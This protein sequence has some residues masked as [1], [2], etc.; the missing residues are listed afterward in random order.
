MK[1]TRVP[2][3]T[4]KFVLSNLGKGERF[5][6][7]MRKI[8]TIFY[9]L[10]QEDV[11]E[12][13]FEEFVFDTSK[14]YPYSEEVY[15]AFDRLQKSNLL[16]IINNEEYEITES[17]SKTDPSKLFT[18]KEMELLKEIAKKFLHGLN[19]PSLSKF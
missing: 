5:L 8:N 7:N 18:E 14:I 11:F 2:S 1:E 15:I 4:I 6:G 12:S 16:V 17:L 9:E 3:D 13:L 19:K 10:S